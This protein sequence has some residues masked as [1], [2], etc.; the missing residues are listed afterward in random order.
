MLA[1]ALLLTGCGGG[2][3]SS[4]A[5][6]TPAGVGAAGTYGGSG[7]ITVSGSGVSVTVPG[8]ITFTISPTG[9]VTVDTGDA[10]PGSGALA[11]DTFEAS[12]PLAPIGTA[13]GL[14]CSGEV[15]Y[16]GTVSGGSITGT[17]S[18]SGARCNG[19]A[20]DVSGSFS[21][22]KVGKAPRQRDS[23]L[24]DALYRAVRIGR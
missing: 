18:S 2:G 19:L 9:M 11:G 24:M 16:H 20:M 3:T 21:A 23:L 6:P 8:S 10:A 15:L 5:G 7:T 13:S 4:G 1:L 17:I 14:S 22:T 12:Q